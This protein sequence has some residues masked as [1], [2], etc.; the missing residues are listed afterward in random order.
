MIFKRTKILATL[1][2]NTSTPEKIEELMNA[3]V[4]GFRLNFSHG[5][6]E[7]RDEQIPWIRQASEKAGKPVA[8]LQ[9]LQGPK[10]R[11]GGLK[12]NTEVKKGDEIVLDYAAEHDG[13]TFPVQYNLA[14]KV[15]VGEPI[16]IFDGKVRTT[17]VEI[18]SD[19][20]IK[21]RVENDGVLMSRKG[22][23]LPDTDFGGDILTPKDIAD[24]EYGAKAD[25][26]YVALSFVQ[27]A[28]DINN[29][30]QMLVSLG[31]TAQIISKIETK[32]AIETD[33]LRAIVQASDGVM[34]A[35]G[36]LAVEA[37]A[38][39]VPVVQRQIIELCRRYGKLS[40]VATQMMASMVDNPEPTRAEVSDVATAVLLG[41]DTV[42]LSDETANGSYPVE[43]VK[44]MKKTILYTQEH[45]PVATFDSV[46]IDS[47]AKRDAISAA[48][49][50]IAEQLK[51]NAIVAETKSGAT[52][53]SIAAFR[54]NLP[55]ISVTSEKRT[56]QLLALSYA[57]KS[58][59]H[60][61]GD[62]AGLEVA[63]RLQEENY[64]DTD[65]QPVSVVIVSGKQPGV[66]GETDTIRVRVL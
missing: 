35:R 46:L 36:D 52:A 64:F 57:N 25:I 6:H 33:T 2:P 53:I 14:E 27:S 55:I 18:P 20:A 31:S 47:I 34:V 30:R 54:P 41:A 21:L 4:N 19:T 38:E 61:D 48:A 23:N 11:L 43:T 1:G 51:V 62:K 16:Y 17:V 28:E 66:T 50:K 32:A 9:D 15:K 12:E 59:V 26:D 13:L 8:I 56:A 44:A 37:G 29:L 58:Y 65:E 39:V 10:I 22:I 24:I 5:S 40:I 60:P 42:M 49:V 3:G 7:E 45:L 63:K